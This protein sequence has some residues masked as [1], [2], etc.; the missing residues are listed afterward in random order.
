MIKLDTVLRPVENVPTEKHE[1]AKER[2]TEVT[3]LRNVI[4]RHPDSG[5]V[6]VVHATLPEGQTQDMARA[7]GRWA[8]RWNGF[9]G[10]GRQSCIENEAFTFGYRTASPMRQRF[11]CGA[12]KFL[13]EEPTASAV[14]H[15]LGLQTWGI[16]KEH[17]PEAAKAHA[18]LCREIPDHWLMDTVEGRIPFSSGVVNKTAALPYHT[19]NGNVKLSWSMMIVLRRGME[20]GELHCPEIDSY[21]ACDDCSVTI[22]NGQS[23]KHGVTPLHRVEG[24]GYRYSVVYY[25]KRGFIGAGTPAEEVRK[26]QLGATRSFSERKWVGEDK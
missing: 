20:G 26:A 4:V 13:V 11:G 2:P 8:D 21:F 10:T 22:F 23:I 6:L 3:P 16:M 5:E 18:E 7:F 25:S 14:L 1:R 24:N 15:D 9:T 19:D 17:A 12:G